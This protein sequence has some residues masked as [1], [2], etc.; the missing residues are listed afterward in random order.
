MRAG[1]QT[2]LIFARMAVAA[3]RPFAFWAAE[4][5]PG[6]TSERN[7]LRRGFDIGY[8]RAHCTRALAVNA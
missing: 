5:A 2:A 7:Y 8:T 4:V 3:T 6:S 1:A